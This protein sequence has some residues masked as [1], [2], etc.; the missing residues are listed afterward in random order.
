M[1]LHN[2]PHCG[3]TAELKPCTAYTL[4]GVRIRCTSCGIGTAPALEGV[5]L[6]TGEFE[7]LFVMT[8]RI[9]RKWNARTEVAV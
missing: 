4:K 1:K 9:V 6:V 3:G 7:P 2:C 8:A 5:N